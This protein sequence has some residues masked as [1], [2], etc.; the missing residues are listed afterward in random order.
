[1]H[2][3]LWHVNY[4]TLMMMLADAPRHL[5]ASERKKKERNQPKTTLADIIKRRSKK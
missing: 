1:M 3:I 5:S 4:Q 2:D